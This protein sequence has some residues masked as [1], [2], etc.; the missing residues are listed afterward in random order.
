MIQIAEQCPYTGGNAV[1]NARVMLRMYFDTLQFEHECEIPVIHNS[2]SEPDIQQIANKNSASDKINIYP[3]P[4][5]NNLVIE[6]DLSEE[7]SNFVIS[8]IIGSEVVAERLSGLAGRHA[9]DVST[10][11]AGVY[12]YKVIS[13]DSI[14]SSGKLVIV[15]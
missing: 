3:N 6:Y 2:K 11:P 10:L 1:Y 13:D 14:I 7:V 8:T 15:K 4:A 5:R 12:L 9:I